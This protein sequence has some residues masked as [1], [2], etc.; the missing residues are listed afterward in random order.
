VV[1][2]ENGRGDMAGKKMEGNEDQ[3][4]AAARQAR[5]SGLEPSEAGVTT[6]ASKQPTHLRHQD[7]LTHE[8]RLAERHRGKQ[9]ELRP[10]PPAP[11]AQPPEAAPPDDTVGG[12][13]A[14]L[15]HVFRALTE[16]QAAHG[17]DAVYVQDV[18]EVARLPVD[19]TRRCCAIWSA[20]RSWSQSSK[21]PM[22]PTWAR[23]SP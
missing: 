20:F 22:T 5:E 9:Q 2:N 3:R 21:G 4:R 7:S 16:A 17:G 12:H 8:E 18:A 15:E 11:A 14:D 6:G 23:A 13:D 1:E 19:R 10:Q